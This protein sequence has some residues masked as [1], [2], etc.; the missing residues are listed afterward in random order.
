MNALTRRTVQ[1]GLAVLAGLAALGCAKAPRPPPRRESLV[2]AELLK[3]DVVPSYL[4]VCPEKAVERVMPLARWRSEHGQRV[5]IATAEAIYAAYGGDRPGPEAIR[6]FVQ[7]LRTAQPGRVKFLLLVGT[8]D[9]DNAEGLYLPTCTVPARFTST[10]MPSARTLV[11]DGPY[12]TP[13]AAAPDLAVG[14]LPARSLAALDAMV[15]KTLTFERNNRPGQWRRSADS[16]A[17]Q[18]GYGRIVDSFLE[19][20]FSSIMANEVPNYLNIHLSYA[21]PASPFCYA[22]SRFSDHIVERLSAGP[23]LMVYI[24][25]GSRNSFDWIWWRGRR[26]DILTSSA[27]E[28]IRIP[29]NRTIVVAVCC[30]TGHFDAPDPCIGERLL[31]WAD[32]PA[33]FIGSSRISQPY[34]NAVLGA[35]LNE[36]LLKDPPAT[37]GEAFLKVRQWLARD[38]KTGFRAFV[39]LA[40]A[41]QLGFAALPAQRADQLTL[42]NILGDPALS[43]GIVRALA[44]LEAPDA[45]SPAQAVE[46]RMKGPIKTGTAHFSLTVPRDRALGRVA[47]VPESHPDAEAEMIRVNARANNKV[48]LQ[49]RVKIR[50]GRAAWTFHVPQAC[51]PGTLH[52]NVYAEGQDRDAAATR[53]IEITPV[54][55]QAPKG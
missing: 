41:T 2:L 14:R 9:A 5:R 42:Y 51:P 13:G 54:E 8:A 26:Y 12:A 20:I 36:A 40:A 32:G 3:P 11:G 52:V 31:A 17:S 29:Y 55:K 27:V 34:A 38:R 24:G 47:P 35:Y 23:A 10:R 48:V 28:S 6:A 43:L 50:A 45:A 15:S 19:R 7:S 46:V 30:S 18:G 37:V 1:L 22:P 21:R 16:F 49:Q 33:L 25:H 53:P 44:S 4:V 39:D